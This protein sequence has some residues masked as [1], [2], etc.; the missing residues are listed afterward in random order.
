MVFKAFKVSLKIIDNRVACDKI[1]AV[2]YNNFFVLT[3]NESQVD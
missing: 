3:L 1:D 2:I